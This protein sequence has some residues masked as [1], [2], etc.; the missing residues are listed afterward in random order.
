MVADTH[1]SKVY[2][3]GFRVA[4]TILVDGFGAGVWKIVKTK[5]VAMLTVEPFAP[6]RAENRQALSDEGEGLVR[7]VEGDAKQFEVRFTE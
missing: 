2:L 7:F 1:R 6:L 3:P 4:A 5:R